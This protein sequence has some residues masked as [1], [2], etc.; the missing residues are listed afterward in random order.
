VED[1]TI[2]PRAPAGIEPATLGLGT[3]AQLQEAAG[4][5]LDRGNP[6]L[7]TIL[8]EGSKRQD[9][10]ST[11]QKARWLRKSLRFGA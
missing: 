4:D 10:S 1:S 9:G 11:V 7:S 2:S 6:L 8:R 5:L 3:G